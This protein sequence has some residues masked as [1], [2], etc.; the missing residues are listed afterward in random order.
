M[1]R[2]LCLVVLLSFTCVASA[3]AQSEGPLDQKIVATTPTA[4]VSKKVFDKKFL[5]LIGMLHGVMIVDVDSTFDVFR[6]C[7]RCTEDN[8]FA[9]PFVERGPVWTYISNTGIEVGLLYAS[10]KMR[11][12]KDPVAR[13]IWW[14]IPVTV[15]VFH[16]EAANHNYKLAESLR[17]ENRP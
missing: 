2:V 10:H 9:R 4:V 14:I 11:E 6:R 8:V 7:P 12:S 3:Q 16:A 1:T 5:A 15:A 17:L 13:R